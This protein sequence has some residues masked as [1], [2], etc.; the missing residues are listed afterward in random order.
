MPNSRSV[1][2]VVQLFLLAGLVL[3]CP[4]HALP[5]ERVGV[6]PLGG[7]EIDAAL[8]QALRPLVGADARAPLSEILANL[9]GMELLLVERAH[10]Q[11][12]ATTRRAAV[13]VYDYSSDELHRFVVDLESQ[14]VEE[15]Q[16]D[17]GVQPPLNENEIEAALNL[18]FQDGP[19]RRRLREEYLRV[20]GEVLLNSDQLAV[21]AFVFHAD[22]RPEGLGED[23]ARCGMERCAQLVISTQDDL[24]LETSP[25][26]SLSRAQVAQ[27]TTFGEGGHFH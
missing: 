21:K 26:L 16:V 8:E 25:I 3:V 15:H 23:A 20:T 22:S 1:L 2:A 9:E 7:D 18:A 13:L 5:S 11:K 14:H 19:L 12:G 27:R 10:G 24:L 4:L 17:Q 6:D